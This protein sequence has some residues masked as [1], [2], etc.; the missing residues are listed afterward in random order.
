MFKRVGVKVVEWSGM[1]G[2]LKQPDEKAQ[3]VQVVVLTLRLSEVP[4]FHFRIAQISEKLFS[5][6]TFLSDQA[7]MTVWALQHEEV[8]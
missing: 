6:K 2:M 3:E 8:F 1:G 7:N 4:P 5:L